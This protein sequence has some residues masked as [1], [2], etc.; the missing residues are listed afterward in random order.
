MKTKIALIGG[1]GFIG[2]ALKN[3]YA[4]NGYD[5]VSYEIGLHDSVDDSLGTICL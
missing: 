2:S 5:I 4:K 3:Y 1:S